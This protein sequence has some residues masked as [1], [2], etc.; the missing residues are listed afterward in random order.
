MEEIERKIQTAPHRL[1]QA[2]NS[3][4]LYRH[5]QRLDH[6]QNRRNRRKRKYLFQLLCKKR[7][8]LAASRRNRPEKALE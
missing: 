6:D 7:G 5:R 2:E 1:A 8:S 3:E 4:L